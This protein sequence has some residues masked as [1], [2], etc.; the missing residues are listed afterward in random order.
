MLSFNGADFNMFF[1]GSDL[2]VDGLDLDAFYLVDSD[3]LLLSFNN[4]ATIGSL[5]LVDDSDIVQF[6][7]TSLGVNTAGT[8][9]MFCDASLV[10]LDTEDEDLD[11]IELLPDG[12]LLIS[13]VGRA[14]VP[15]L[16]GL[17]QDEDLLA[18]TPSAP[19]N[20]SSGTWAVYFDG[21]DVSLGST[22][23]EDLDGLD[24]ASNGDIYLTT[25]GSFAVS[26]ISGADEDVFV[27]G[28]PVTGATT[29]CAFSPALFLDGSLWG[30][31]PN[32]VDAI[33]LP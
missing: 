5:G 13:T 16:S 14:S 17:W 15:G 1:D 20:Y 29:A 33:T 6:D 7:A 11:A 21:S 18:F 10:G 32:D 19:G 9:S 30:L 25:I 12:Q 2:G 26:G 23:G 28:S 4:A 24:V 22:S 3:T 27:C 31:G 8:F